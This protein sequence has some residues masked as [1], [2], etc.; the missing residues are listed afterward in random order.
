MSRVDVADV[1]DLAE[2]LPLWLRVKTEL[3]RGPLTLAA[4]AEELGA[5]VN[6][7]EKA[8][9]RKSAVFTRLSGPDGIA[10]VALLETRA[11]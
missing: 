2:G 6:S 9:K 1:K 4:L 5:P 8:V 7:I 10:R 3:R 11:A